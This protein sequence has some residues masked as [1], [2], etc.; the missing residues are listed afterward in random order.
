MNP[1]PK[2]TLNFYNSI[3]R[4]N[5]TPTQILFSTAA[6]NS[7]ASSLGLSLFPEDTEGPIL[8]SISGA[9]DLSNENYD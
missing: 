5:D 9:H 1:N 7:I 6:Y 3:V 2:E 8:V 4:G